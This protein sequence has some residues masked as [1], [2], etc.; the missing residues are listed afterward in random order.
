MPSDRFG[1]RP[2]L[3]FGPIIAGCGLALLAFSDFRQSY[4]AGV[5]PAISVFGVGITITVPPLTSTVMSS[6]G[7]LHVGVASGV[8][9]AVAR[10]AGLFAVAALGA[11]LSTS[12]SHHFAG[13]P[14]AQANETLNAILA[15]QAGVTQAATAAFN[16]ALRTALLVAACCA[17]TGGLIGWLWIRPGSVRGA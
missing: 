15:G 6:V 10:V 14:V 7:E 11:V 13:A 8:N 17:V 4:W 9:N 3:T 2:S 5:F 1:P 16:D 12:F